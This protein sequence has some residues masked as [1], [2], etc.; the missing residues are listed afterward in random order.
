MTVSVKK[1][2]YKSFF[3]R[4]FM[5]NL[6]MLLS[7]ED[8]DERNR[9]RKAMEIYQRSEG[10]TPILISGS[11]SGY[12]GRTI[13]QG[14]QPECYQA[15]DF[16]ISQGIP[17][18]DIKVEDSSLDTLGN[19][20]FSH[21]IIGKEQEIDLV[22]DTFHMKRSLWCARL[23]FGDSKRFIPNTTDKTGN[24]KYQRFMEGLQIRLLSRD[25]GK[26]GVKE[27]DYEALGRFM[28][29]VHPFYCQGRPE[30]SAF[31]FMVGMF[32]NKRLMRLL[33]TQ[34]Q[35]YKTPPE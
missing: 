16:L 6:I 26:Y 3:G 30:P 12:L 5:S 31:G 9:S 19:F 22:T 21:P 23:V 24:T 13:P 29:K 1:R 4:L 25:M 17:E 35:A 32:N 34:K 10:A 11:H 27:G 33:P 8:V 28:N 20:Y 15:R 14:M 7:G 18:R 2:V